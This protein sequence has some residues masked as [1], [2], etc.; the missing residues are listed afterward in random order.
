MFNLFLNPFLHLTWTMYLFLIRNEPNMCRP[1]TIYLH[2]FRLID[3][4]N[5]AVVAKNQSISRTLW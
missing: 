3:P 1:L 2:K 4:F 5:N